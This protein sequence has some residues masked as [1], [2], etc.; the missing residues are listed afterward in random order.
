VISNNTLSTPATAKHVIKMHAP[1]AA[2]GLFTEQGVI[3]DNKLIG[4]NNSWTVSLE[5]ES[6][7]YD[8]RLRNL[9]V[10]RNWFTAGVGTQVALI[11]S[12]AE[13]TIRNNIMD[14]SG[15][16]AFTCNTVTQ[17]GIEP[18]PT[19]VRYYNNTCYNSAAAGTVTA[20]SLGATVTNITAQNNLASVP[21]GTGTMVSGIGA[22][23]LTAANNLFNNVPATLFANATPTTPAHFAL[24]GGSPA[25][26]FGTTVPVQTDFFYN[27]AAP[28]ARPQGGTFD[29]GASEF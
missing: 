28:I 23:G 9:I 25:I 21:G 29:A 12:G 8:Q 20:I 10:E 13:F 2:S 4:A 14:M 18:V 24:T 1:G 5:P 3:S 15:G 17:R 26:G 19:D 7:S 16:A 11:L 27:G 6:A 22:S